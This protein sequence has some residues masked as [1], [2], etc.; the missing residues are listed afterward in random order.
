MF[1]SGPERSGVL[2][3]DGFAGSPEVVW[4][5][6]TG[7]D[8]YSSPAVIGGIAYF[9]SRDGRFYAVDAETGETRWSLDLGSP[10]RSSPTVLDGTVY[11]GTHDHRV[12]ALDARSGE[13]KWEFSTDGPV[14]SSPVVVGDT[15]FIGSGDGSIYAIDVSNGEERW[16]YET[17]GIVG[18]S[19]AVHDGTVYI[20]S[21][22]G[23]MYAIGADTGEEVW[24]FKTGDSIYSTPAVSG[25]SL[26]FGSLD[27]RVYALDRRT[28]SLH[29]SFTTEGSLVWSS[30]AVRDGLVYVGA[31][32]SN[33]Y[34]L[35]A[36]TGEVVWRYWTGVKA[37]YSSP[38]LAGGTI[39]FGGRDGYLYAV[40][41][42]KGTLRWKFQAGDVIESSPAVYAGKVYFGCADGKVYA[43]REEMEA[44]FEALLPGTLGDRERAVPQL[45]PDHRHLLGLQNGML[46]LTRFPG[47]GFIRTFPAEEKHLVRGFIWSPRNDAF[48]YHTE[49][50]EPGGSGGVYLVKLD[51][52]TQKVAA[53]EPPDM[54]P[55]QMLWSP[56]GR[57]L[58]WDKPFSIYDRETGRLLVREDIDDHVRSP[59]FSE[60]GSK[61]ALTL[62]KDDGSENLWVMDLDSGSIRQVTNAGEGDYPFWWMDDTKLMVRIGAV[63]TGGGLIYGLAAV[64]LETGSRVVVD[65]PSGGG[66]LDGPPLRRIHVVKGVSPKGDHLVGESRSAAGTESR[67]YLLDLG[68]GRREVILEGKTPSEG[69]G[70]PQVLWIDEEQMLLSLRKESYGDVDYRSQ[71]RYQIVEYSS[72][73]GCLLLVE[74]EAR[75]RLLSIDDN[76]LYYLELDG[77]GSYWSVRHKSLN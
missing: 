16:S 39:Y 15:L 14:E 70:L 4:A 3:I 20:G 19:P 37:I 48:A 44:L 75:M 42:T 53:L 12:Y 76:R 33:L 49:H 55:R 74:S 27:G 25:D 61:L 30:P 36:E 45:S 57:Y 71:D 23:F 65:Y 50:E 5:F 40:D 9:G 69:Y 8:V 67:I 41:A 29:W 17:K 66:G 56:C 58:F 38:L 59:L 54:G 10:V 31:F 63:S 62:L 51:G 52:S 26:F 68:T 22:D 6:E 73:N 64:D 18:C 77:T 32:D 24:R 35:D 1:R 7:D 46:T 72:G 28:G 13:R 11:F 43:L 21:Y 2:D 60:N 47:N 34:A